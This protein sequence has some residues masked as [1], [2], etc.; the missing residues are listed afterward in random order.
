MAPAFAK[1]GDHMAVA[2]EGIDLNT[3][4]DGAEAAALRQALLDNL[5][6]CIRGQALAPVAYRE[7]M[8]IFGTLVLQTR[9]ENRHDEVA[10][11]MIL[12]SEDR[13][14]LG[15]GKPLVVGAHWHS[16][17]SYKAV[18]CAL[19][20]LYG[21]AVP[22][23]GGDTQFI[24]MYA[25]YDGLSPALRR[26]IDGLK[27]VHTYDSSRKGTRIARLNAAE[28]AALPAIV[29]PLVRTHPETG[30]RALYMN[31]NRMEAV[32]GMARAESD[33]LLDALTDHATQP[34][35]Q[36]RHR[37]RQGD[38]LIWDNRCT[39]HKANADYPAG[40]RRVMQRLMVAGTAPV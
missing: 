22:P 30:R 7:A 18:P 35:Y 33:A 21:V 37:W 40:S 17:D 34:Q 15:D 16:D 36:Y 23:V 25:A 24:N 31:P 14:R 4:V 1:H 3:P 12:S 2:V 38:I 32:V 8:R 13:D 39:M 5:V 10:E 6:L 27:V 11:I 19:T 9:A 20:I 28:A 29:H 26:R